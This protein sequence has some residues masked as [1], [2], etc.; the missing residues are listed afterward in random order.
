MTYEFPKIHI[1]H[2]STFVVLLSKEKEKL[3]KNKMAS[4]QVKEINI[5]TLF[6]T[7]EARTP[8]QLQASNSLDNS[9]SQ[10]LAA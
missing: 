10:S 9:H 2:I 8:R 1:R 7:E 6:R 5:D 3:I 4:Q